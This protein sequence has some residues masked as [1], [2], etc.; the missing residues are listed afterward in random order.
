M[1]E[2]L[3]L[4]WG[5]LKGWDFTENEAAKALLQEYSDIGC[6]AGAIQQ[7]DTPRQKEIICELIDACNGPIHNDWT[8][9]DMSKDEAKRYVFEYG[10]PKVAQ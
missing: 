1:A 10:Q 3:T 9:E 4:K 2:H 7:R 8:G 6:A 5:T